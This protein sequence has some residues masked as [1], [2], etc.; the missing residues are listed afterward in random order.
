MQVFFL[1]LV[2]SQFYQCVSTFILMLI[3]NVSPHRK[4]TPQHIAWR[5][6]LRTANGKAWL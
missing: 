5:Y 1:F 3:P 6:Q 2:F 4:K